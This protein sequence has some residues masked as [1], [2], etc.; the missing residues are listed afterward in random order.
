MDNGNISGIRSEEEHFMLDKAAT[1][2]CDPKVKFS[3]KEWIIKGKKV[4]E[5][6]IHK[7][8]DLPTKAPDHSGKM[9]AF[10]RVNDQNILANGIQMKI[11]QK[12][13][14]NKDV[15]FV[16]SQEA[17]QLLDLFKSGHR[18]SFNHIQSSI[19]ISRYRI[20]N[21]IANLII[22]KV[23]IMEIDDLN[24]YFMLNEYLDN[25]N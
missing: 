9:K 14:I 4:L 16:Y 3:S 7:G 25:D 17:K 24:S 18:L 11:W 8:E 2:Y 15:N 10:V 20:E 1:T 6:N 5:V 13:S 22:M 12:L 23:I 19:S 21:M